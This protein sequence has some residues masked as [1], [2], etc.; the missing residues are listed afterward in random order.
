MI[1]E[2]GH[3]TRSRMAGEGRIPANLRFR[4]GKQPLLSGQKQWL[5]RDAKPAGRR[6]PSGY[7]TTT[8]IRHT[9]TMYVRVQ[10]ATR[11]E[12]GE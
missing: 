6:L 8:S 5:R 12:R 1:D 11:Q 3:Q 2:P 7:A 9:E 4:I 10:R